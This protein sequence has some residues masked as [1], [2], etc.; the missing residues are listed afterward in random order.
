MQRISLDRLAILFASSPALVE[1]NV[2]LGLKKGAVK[3]RDDATKKFGHYQPQVGSFEAWAVL[4]TSTV[5]AKLRAG[6]AGDDPLIGHYTGKAQNSVWST[7]LHN[8]IEYEVSGLMAQVGTQ[9]PVGLWQEYGTS[10]GIPP[11]PFLR[12]ALW[13]NTDYIK[14]EIGAAMAEVFRAL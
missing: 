4:A 13:E 5:Q 6:S 10:R 9:D 1:A 8:T 2:K 11:R 7:P 3:V 12:P 14:S